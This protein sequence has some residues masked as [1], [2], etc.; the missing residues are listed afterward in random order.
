MGYSKNVPNKCNHCKYY[1][2]KDILGGV[3][4][5]YADKVI[6]GSL[7]NSLNSLKN[8]INK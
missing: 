1:I 4:L 6:D 7:K 5:R 3:V 2:N 8:N